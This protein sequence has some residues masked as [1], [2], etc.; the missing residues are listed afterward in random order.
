MRYCDITG[1]TRT[2]FGIRLV[3]RELD[4]DVAYN[5]HVLAGYE[6]QHI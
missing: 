1:Y 3:V 2:E 4:F 6:R 5:H